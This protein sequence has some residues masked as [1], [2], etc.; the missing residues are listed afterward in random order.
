MYAARST[1]RRELMRKIPI[2]AGTMR[3]SGT[4][5]KKRTAMKSL[6]VGMSAYITGM[7]MEALLFTAP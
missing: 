5:T 4:T 7:I 6:P 2:S 3:R 1:L